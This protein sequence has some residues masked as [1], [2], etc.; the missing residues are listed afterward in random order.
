MDGINMNDTNDDNTI[1]EPQDNDNN[2]PFPFA[3]HVAAVIYA[4]SG[5]LVMCAA[6][7][8]VFLA[9]ALLI[10]SFISACAIFLIY[11]RNRIGRLF[12]VYIPLISISIFT[13]LYIY[14]YQEGIEPIQRKISS[15]WAW[16]FTI[17]LFYGVINLPASILLSLPGVVSI[18][19]KRR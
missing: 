2:M 12:A 8:A 11:R 13:L 15:E 4:I 7:I 14:A 9:P 18:Y 19:T 16:Y 3:V 10:Y 1:S 17:G 6:A 5:F